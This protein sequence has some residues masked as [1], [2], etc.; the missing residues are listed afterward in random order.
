MVAFAARTVQS[1]ETTVER[2]DHSL[3]NPDNIAYIILCRSI[4]HVYVGLCVLWLLLLHE[5]MKMNKTSRVYSLLSQH[6][7]CF[8]C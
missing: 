1:L 7:F 4:V 6:R 5:E 3:A 2:M 8:E